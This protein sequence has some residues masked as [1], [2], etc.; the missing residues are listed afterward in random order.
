MGANL[1]AVR[2]TRKAIEAFSNLPLLKLLRSTN[3]SGSSLGCN[4]LGED[5][6]VADPRVLV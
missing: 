1:S 3:S 6:G 2:K 4:T 5:R